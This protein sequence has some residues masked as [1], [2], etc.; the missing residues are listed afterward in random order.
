MEKIKK[1]WKIVII[2]LIIT[3]LYSLAVT[4][5]LL[6]SYKSD[7]NIV[8]GADELNAGIKKT[9]T[10][11]IDLRDKKDYEAGHIDGAI[12]MPYTDGGIKMLDYLGE[13]ADKSY[14]IYLMCYYGNR[15][16]MAFNLLR[17]EGYKKLYYV[18]FGYEEYANTMGSRF[19]PTQGECPCKNYD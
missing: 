17:D 6:I 1:N 16:G 3:T 11:L 10:I 12:N 19:N 7:Y 15:S 2:L 13:K 8:I 5:F 18:K 14:K 9:H 4:I